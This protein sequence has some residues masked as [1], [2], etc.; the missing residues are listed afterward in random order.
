MNLMNFFNASLVLSAIQFSTFASADCDGTVG[1]SEHS[2]GLPGPAGD[3]AIAAFNASNEIQARIALLERHDFCRTQWEPSVKLIMKGCPGQIC[4]EV[5]E[6]SLPFRRSR[7]TA[8][9]HVVGHYTLFADGEAQFESKPISL[10]GIGRLVKLDANQSDALLDAMLESGLENPNNGY[11]A[12]NRFLGQLTCSQA[13]VPNP[14]PG[15]SLVNA[16]TTLEAP[17]HA[18]REMMGILLALRAFVGP[19][20]IVGAT[21]VGAALISCSRTVYPGARASCSLVIENR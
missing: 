19:A 15:C 14:V 10:R 5:Y 2:V 7:V 3:N 18:A 13:V 16:D 9:R 17:D 6:V 12:V 20:N 1:G 11:G 21:N 4:R 8:I